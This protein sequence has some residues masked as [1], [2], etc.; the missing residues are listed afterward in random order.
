VHLI[1]KDKRRPSPRSVR[2]ITKRLAVPIR[3]VLVGPPGSTRDKAAVNELEALIRGATTSKRW[4]R[5]ASS[6]TKSRGPLLE[7]L[8]I[9]A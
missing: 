1:E 5:T 6:S 7:R 8:C 2:V 9:F 3:E 4:S